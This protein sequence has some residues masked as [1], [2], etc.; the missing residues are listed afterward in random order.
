MMIFSQVSLSYISAL[1]PGIRHPFN[2]A[3]MQ[4]TLHFF[5][6]FPSPT[7]GFY[8][9]ICTCGGGRSVLVF[10]KNL[11][12]PEH[13]V[14]ND[15]CAHYGRTKEEISERIIKDPTFKK[16][17]R[18]KSPPPS[19][20]HVMF[21]GAALPRGSSREF[22]AFHTSHI[23]YQLMPPP[24]RIQMH[25]SGWNCVFWLSCLSGDD[26]MLHADDP[27]AAQQR[28]LPDET[29]RSPSG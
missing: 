16:A 7:A 8:S 22:L 29:C 10:L 24:P 14:F 3:D 5:V 19:P 9:T 28:D 25:F 12:S 27:L 20:E 13:R 4:S 21:A 23:F 26:L 17:L 2:Y 6:S 11:T 1:T 15:L 18:P